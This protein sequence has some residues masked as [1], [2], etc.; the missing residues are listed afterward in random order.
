MFSFT[1]ENI[2]GKVKMEITEFA[3]AA[4]KIDPKALS[5]RGYEDGSL[6]IIR[7]NGRKEKYTQEKV[8]E[9]LKILNQKKTPIK[10]RSTRKTKEVVEKKEI[11][12]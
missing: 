12:K 2:P 9:I 8:K 6:V 3:K 4:N 1:S 10:K 11:K 5:F 7:N